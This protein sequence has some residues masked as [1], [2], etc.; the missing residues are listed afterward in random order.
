M[1]S[2]RKWLLYMPDHLPISCRF[3]DQQHCFS[4]WYESRDTYQSTK[5]IWHFRYH[6]DSS[7]F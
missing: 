1:S 6:A 2:V 5:H 3:S 7:P 4:S